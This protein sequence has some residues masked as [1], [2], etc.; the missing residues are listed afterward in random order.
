[1]LNKEADRTIAH[2]SLKLVI[3]DSKYLLVL[4]AEEWCLQPQLEHS[5][6]KQVPI[7]KTRFSMLPLTL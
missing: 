1:V 6:W 2:S 4:M 7:C 3:A 5:F